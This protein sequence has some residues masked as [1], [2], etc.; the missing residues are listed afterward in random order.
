MT[1][2]VLSQFPSQTYMIRPL[3]NQYLIQN[4]TIIKEYKCVNLLNTA[5]PLAA[6]ETQGPALAPGQTG[7][8]P[9]V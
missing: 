9:A 7:P 5:F 6:T 8:L 1:G 4:I 2:H 3:S